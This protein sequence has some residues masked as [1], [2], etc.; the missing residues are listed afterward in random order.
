MSLYAYQYCARRLC[1]MRISW[2][3]VYRS[4]CALR[5][6]IIYILDLSVSLI[7]AIVV[8][9]SMLKSQKYRYVNISLTITESAF[10]YVTSTS[11]HAAALKRMLVGYA[12]ETFVANVWSDEAIFP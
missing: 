5:V 9:C 6:R 12:N 8:N 2:L 7:H 4:V 1:E 3:G 11:H 10:R